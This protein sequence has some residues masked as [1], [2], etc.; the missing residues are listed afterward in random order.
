MKPFGFVE[1]LIR[2]LSGHAFACSGK[3]KVLLFGG[4]ITTLHT[5]RACLLFAKRFR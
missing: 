3:Q 5:A 1:K 2:F 4:Q